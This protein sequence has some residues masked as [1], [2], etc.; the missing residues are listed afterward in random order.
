MK[1]RKLWALLLLGLLQIPAFADGGM[2]TLDMLHTQIKKMK[3]MGLKLDEL[4]LYDPSGTPSIKDGVVFFDG[5]CS[6]VLVSDQSLLLTNHHCGYDQIQAHSSVGANYLRDGFVSHNLEEEL[7]CPGLVVETVESIREVTVKVKALLDTRKKEFKTGLEYLSP[8]YL[9]GLAKDIVSAKDYKT[10]Y[11]RYEI[12]AFYGGNK[13]YLFQY[14]R[15]TDVRLVAAPP[16]S[17]GK[18]GADTD[19]WIW[20]RHTGDFSMFRLYADKN[21]K[22]ADYNKGN[23]PYKPKKFIQINGNGVSEGDFVMIMGFPGTTYHYFTSEEVKEWGEIDNNIR[24]E[25]RGIRQNIMLKAMHSNEKT[26]IMYA[27]KY[28]SSQNGY[29]RAQGA[30]WAIEKRHLQA[31]KLAQQEAL[32]KRGIA[33]SDLEASNAAAQI[34]QNIKARHQLRYRER[35]LVEGILYG[36]EFTMAPIA[37]RDLLS[38]NA[39]AKTKAIE[40]L[41][42]QFNKFYDKDYSP[43]LDKEIAI[44]MLERYCQRV[45]QGE[46]PKAI[47]EGI[48]KFGSVKAYIE[49]IF[50]NSVFAS[51]ERFNKMLSEADYNAALADPMSY[52]AQ[53]VIDEYKSLTNA[54][55]PYDAPIKQAQTAYIKANMKYPGDEVLWPDANLTLRFTYGKVK[56]YIPRDVVT[57]GCVSTMDGVMEKEDPTNPEYILP[58]KLKDIYA[59]KDFG[60]Y[61]I[62]GTTTMPVNFCATTHTTGGNSGSPVF[63][64]NGMLV[65]LNFDRNWEGVG[66]DIEYL[67]NYQRSIILDIRYLMLIVDKYLGGENLIKEMNPQY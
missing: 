11:Y 9:S 13:Y 8:S 49:Y 33:N 15:F 7:P 29:K 60:K 16:S 52:F 6:G 45:K 57:Y 53:S 36:I 37:S 1:S 20:P 35:Y 22:P 41:T 42:K 65:G 24:I 62:K 21:G 51:K 63:D 32:I 43:E 27:A 18:Y 59:K 56:G 64:G 47:D 58:Q 19:N 30:N 39:T 34:A 14:K 17:I 67:A 40:S 12:K 38:Q 50:A 66:G 28:A 44:A 3:E 5:G 46:R 10:P 2:W 23:V 55:L 26:E 4:N 25:M 31:T 54:L 48:E 61:A